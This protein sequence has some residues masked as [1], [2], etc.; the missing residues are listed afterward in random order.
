MLLLIS[1]ALGAPLGPTGLLRPGL[2]VAGFV[3]SGHTWL[4]ETSC[5][6]E[7]CDAWRQD[8]VYGGEVGVGVLPWLGFYAHGG[9]VQESIDAAFYD[10][11]GYAFGGGGR[12][13]VPL[14]E[15][16]GL[17]AWVGLE[18]QLT[19]APADNERAAMWSVEAGGQLRGGRPDEGIQVWVG[20]AVVP[21]SS[22]NAEF[23]G[24]DVKVSLAPRVPVTGELGGMWTSDPL[25]GPWD[26]RTRLSAGFIGTVGYRAGV[27]GFLGVVY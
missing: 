7:R 16:A 24:G 13:N 15:L 22:Q 11:N 14:G 23:L 9:W 4:R 25:F 26:D 12:A 18:N 20:G 10:A 27:T 6:A 3:S 19:Y 2:E 17:H 8:T 1:I 21:W 5:D